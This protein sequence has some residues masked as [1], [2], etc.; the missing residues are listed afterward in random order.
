MPLGLFS[1]GKAQ[2]LSDEKPAGSKKKDP[3][4]LSENKCKGVSLKLDHTRVTIEKQ[5]AEGG[6]AIVYIASDRKNN[7]FALKRQFTKENQKQLDACCREHSFL[8]QCVGHKNIVEFVDS[9]VNCLGNGIWECMLLTEYHQR[10]VLQLMNERIS[11]NQYLTNE[12]ILSIFSDLCEAVSFIHNRPQPIIH[13]DL[14]VENMLI[15]SHKPPNYVLCDFGSATTQVLSIDKFGV[16][17]VKSEVE[18][19]TTMCYRSPEM[20]DLYSGQELGLKGDIWALGVLLYRLCYFCVPFEESPLAIQSVN[21]QFPN[22]P[23]I[24]DE[25]KVLIYMILD[26]DV[27]RRPSI[28]QTASLAFEAYGKP[29]PT[30]IQNKKLTDTAPRLKSCIQLMNDGTKPR[31]KRE[32]SPRTAEQPPITYLNS[33]VSRNAHNVTSAANVVPSV[34]GS[35]ETSVAPRLRPKATNT[36]PNVP[37]ISPVPPLGLSHLK[38]PSKLESDETNEG[39]VQKGASSELHR[40]SFSGDN[41]LEAEQQ[42]SSGPLSCPL[43]KPSDLG[44]TDL[45]K[46]ALPRDRAQTDGKRR[47][48]HEADIIFHQQHRRN[49]SDTSQISRS[50]FKPYS[51]QQTTSKATSQVVRS[52]EDMSNHSSNNG[53]GEWNPFLAAPFSN[54]SI[55]RKDFAETGFMMDDSHFGMVF[56]EIRRREVPTELESDTSSIDSRDPFGAAPFDQLTVSTSSSAQPVSLPPAAEEDDERQLIS[57]TDEEDREEIVAGIIEVKKET[58]TEEDSEIDEQRMN[59]RRRYSYENIDGVGDDA[60]SDSRG[61][62]D[63]DDSEEEDDDSR[64]GGDTSHDEDSQNTV[65]SE[66][67]EGGSRPLLEDD[68]LEDDDDHELTSPFSSSSANFPPLFIGTSSPH[69]QNIITNPFLRDELTPKMIS[70]LPMSTALGRN[71]S[72]DDE[73]DLGDRWTDRRDTVFERPNVQQQNVFAPATLPRQVTPL[74]CRLKPDLPTAAPVSIIPSMSN[75]SFPEAIRVS[76]DSLPRE[77]V[78]GTLISVGAPTEPPSP[79][80]IE[81]ILNLETSE[82]STKETLITTVKKEKLEKLL[83]KEKKKEKKEGKKDKLKLE[84]YREKGSSEPETDGSEAEIW[85]ADGSTTLSKKKKKSAFGLRSSHPSIVVNELQFASPVPPVAKKLSKEKKSSLTGKNA[86]FVNTSFQQE[87]HDDPSEM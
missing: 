13:R 1:S 62:T 16:E 7:K 72:A 42:E 4:Q 68:G 66:D 75:T 2:V 21:Y 82:V 86:S 83:K 24:P 57:D 26:I 14:K 12:E 33:S 81:K 54:S 29:L 15:S 74:V 56:D 49:V 30:E 85:T 3:K 67:G 84:E 70:P 87:D 43:M 41:K 38:F 9:Y 79:K 36:V 61:K 5:I 45:D 17:Y 10:N 23:N 76:E 71:P 6:F 18:R 44:F 32:A 47:M 25:T 22:A 19:N 69:T 80:K 34:I 35:G 40:K 55:C 64:R 48:P 65:G 52:V 59:D 11:Q 37:S 27:N 77:P 20:V 28:Y 51:S 58:Q 39:Q 73:W 31:N 50:A 78:I 63:R 60:S 46:P 8:K 53:V